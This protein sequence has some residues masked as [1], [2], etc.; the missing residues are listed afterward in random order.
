MENNN[1]GGGVGCFSLLTIMFIG[2]KLGGVI[3]WSWLWVFAPLWVPFVIAFVITG[4]VFLIPVML[5]T[6]LYLVD[7]FKGK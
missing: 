5:M 6:F 7:K 3:N 1:A 4:L 2:L